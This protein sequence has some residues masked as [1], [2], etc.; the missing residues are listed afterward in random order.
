MESRALNV[1]VQVA[2]T[3]SFVAACRLLGICAS[4]IGKR[5]GALEEQL[6]VRLFH[7]STRSVALTG[8]G[9][10]FLERSRRILGQIEAA[11]AELHC[12]NA[13]LARAAV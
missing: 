5:V 13:T 6:G 10:L 8:E 9:A 12:R 4:A 1:F 3:R 2:E 11:L 7:P